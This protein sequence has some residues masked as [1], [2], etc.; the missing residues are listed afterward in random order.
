MEK[1]IQSNLERPFPYSHNFN[2]GCLKGSGQKNRPILT[3][4]LLNARHVMNYGSQGIKNNVN[5]F[6]MLILWVSIVYILITQK[7]YGQTSQ[8]ILRLFL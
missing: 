6:Q 7:T 5:I 2:L 8:G 3:K 4:I 1:E